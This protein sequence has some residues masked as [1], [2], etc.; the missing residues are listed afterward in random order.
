MLFRSQ[1]GPERGG[2]KGRGGGVFNISFGGGDDGELV[3]INEPQRGDLYRTVSA[4]G[5]IEPERLVEI[6]SQIS[7]QI[8][9]LPFREG[10][11]VEAGDV[12][13]R[14]DPQN[15]TAAINSAEARLLNAQARLDGAKADL[16]SSRLEFDR[17]RSLL[18]TGDVTEAEFEQARATFQRNQ[19][20][21]RAIEADI[22][23]A[24]A[25]IERAQEDLSNTVI[26]SPIAG[27]I[28]ALNAEE[29]ETAI[30]GTTNTPGSVIMEIA[31]LSTMLVIAQ[32][33]ETN[34]AP[35]RENQRASIFVNAYPDREFRG[36]VQRIGL[37]RRETTAGTG[38]F[39]VEILLDLDEGTILR[40][41]LTASVEIEVEQ[42]FDVLKLPTQAVVDRRVD[43]L[44]LRIRSSEFVD[45]SGTF[46]PV[47]YRFDSGR[48]VAT[49][50]RIGPS[51]LTHTVIED[52]LEPDARAITG[53]YRVLASIKDGQPV[54]DEA[55]VAA[56]EAAARGRTPPEAD[57]PEDAGT[58]SQDNGDAPQEGQAGAAG[59]GGDDADGAEDA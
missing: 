56:A 30:V 12:V 36:S 16:V 1:S 4:P 22:A 47:V 42:F 57:E 14:L 58:D 38:Y 27:I 29:G 3:Q 18:E 53:P 5:S 26:E 40:S 13:V 51:D 50:V 35:V 21:V 31:D 17:V 34:I 43:E 8:T 15:L 2:E 52:G 48:A 37:K 19:S 20:N 45:A 28:T 23:V 6:S 49:P 9:A 59:R 41:G 24:E 33:D 25:D 10:E 44:P 54:R 46:T 11:R 7:A 39:E 55:A 32:V